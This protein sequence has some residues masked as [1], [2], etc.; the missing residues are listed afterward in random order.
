MSKFIKLT[1]ILLNTNYIYKIVIKQNKYLIHITGPTNDS[2]NWH[3]I[4][5]CET[6]Q[7][8]DYKIV[9]EWIRNN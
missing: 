8:N 3:F 2:M 4:E 5:L 1:N 6:K 9:S 7:S